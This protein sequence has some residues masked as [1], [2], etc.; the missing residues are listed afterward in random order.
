MIT[1]NNMA[2]RYAAASQHAVNNLSFD[3]RPG[4]IFGLLGPSGAGKST[5]QKILISLLKDFE[6]EISVF[7]K[8]LKKWDNSYYEQVGVSFELPNH[9]LKLTAN[10]NLNY[11]LSLY[12]C[13][14]RTPQEVLS[15]VG[16]ETD[17][18]TLV[19]QY[20]KGMKNRLSVARALLHNPRLIF[21]DEPT[22]GLDPVNARNIKEIILTQKNEGKTV[23][24]TTHDMQVADQLCDRVA[25]I[26][27]GNIRLIDSPHA[28]KIA[29]QKPLVQ[30]EYLIDDSPHVAEFS[31]EGLHQNQSFQKILAQ[32]HLIAIH[33]LDATL[34]DIFIQITGR[35]LS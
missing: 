4:E 31:L 35:S 19:S 24:L 13:K 5:T 28:L 8:D 30:V 22:S 29:Y 17:G 11:Y 26:V 15:W 3:V 23:F 7:G 16:L 27:D 32:N 14:T 2:Y 9:F 20:S 34:E 18:D 25:F 1:V 12:Q 10:E 33:S 21:L 6:G